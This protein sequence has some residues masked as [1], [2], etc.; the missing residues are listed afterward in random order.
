MSSETSRV[1]VG[2]GWGGG[3]GGGEMQ[4]VVET[5]LHFSKSGSKVTL[6]IHWQV[7]FLFYYYDV[8]WIVISTR[9]QPLSHVNVLSQRIPL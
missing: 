7:I 2:L 9:A 3:G 6:I 1:R 4:L 5:N 8:R